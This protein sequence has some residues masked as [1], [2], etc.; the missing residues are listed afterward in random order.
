M[1][2][3][4]GFIGTLVG[5]FISYGL[6]VPS[7]A[8]IILSLVFIFLVARFFRFINEKINNHQHKL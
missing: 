7:G 2:I 6:N 4:I 8:T 3:I 5:L 1:S